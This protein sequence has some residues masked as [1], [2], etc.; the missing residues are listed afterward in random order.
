MSRWTEEDAAKYLARIGGSSSPAPAPLPKVPRAAEPSR[1]EAELLGHL[2]VMQLAPVVQYKFHTE[3]RWRLDFAF[4]DV[5][6]GVELDGGIFAAENGTEAGRHARG[7]GR[8]KDFE[9]RN[10]AAELGWFVLCYGPPQVRT[11][12]AAI[13]IERLVKKL[14][15]L[16]GP[17]PVQEVLEHEHA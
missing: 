10:A 17:G 9:K 6:L 16:R 4:P 5:L 11:G 1:L 12:E 8:V 3:R 7:A 15:L 2:T 14:R 13:Q